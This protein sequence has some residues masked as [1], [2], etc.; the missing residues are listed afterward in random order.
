MTFY[1]SIMLMFEIKKVFNGYY[2]HHKVIF[3]TKIIFTTSKRS[4]IFVLPPLIKL[5][6][7]VMI[8]LLS[9][10]NKR[11]LKSSKRKKPI[12]ETYRT[13]AIFYSILI[14]QSFVLQICLQEIS[15]ISSSDD[16][17]SHL[18]CDR[19]NTDRKESF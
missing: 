6:L 11:S 13:N 10:I 5:F 18:D 2:L 9:R 17:I 16:N 8:F 3:A 19:G 15:R 14:F 7:H 1:S 4:P 12:G